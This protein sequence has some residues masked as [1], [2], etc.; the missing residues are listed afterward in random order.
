MTYFAI[1]DFNV[2]VARDDLMFLVND[3]DIQSLEYL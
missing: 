3:S 2:K 1:D